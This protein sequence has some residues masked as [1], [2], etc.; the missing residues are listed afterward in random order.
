MGLQVGINPVAGDDLKISQLA[1]KLDQPAARTSNL[2]KIGDGRL[3]SRRFLAA[4]VFQNIGD[5]DCLAE[6]ENADAGVRRACGDR[7]SGEGE[8][9]QHR[10]CR[11]SYGFVGS[12]RV[13][14]S[15]MAGFMGDNAFDLIGPVSGGNETRMD[16]HG[17]AAGKGVWRRV[18]DQQNINLISGQARGPE[19]GPRIIVQPFLNLGVAQGVV[20]RWRSQMSLQTQG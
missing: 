15:N 14:A 3:V 18:A 11:R 16:A 9:E 12:G 2:V 20:A 6:T 19:K 7:A 1:K 4:A 10:T 5:A 13:T 17:K 8:A